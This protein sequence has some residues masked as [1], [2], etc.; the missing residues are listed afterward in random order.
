[1]AG[2]SIWQ[3]GCWARGAGVWKGGWGGV[4]VT[5]QS[6]GTMVYPHPPSRRT[7][8]FPVGRSRRQKNGKAVY[9]PLQRC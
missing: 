3:V 8:V 5:P 7:L 4:R 1:M 6:G 2:A 9:S